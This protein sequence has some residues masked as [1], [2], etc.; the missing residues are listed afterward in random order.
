MTIIIQSE[1]EPA[2]ASS[3]S[4]RSRNVT[5]RCG[6]VPFLFESNEVVLQYKVSTLRTA[7]LKNPTS[8][9]TTWT[10][11]AFIRPFYEMYDGGGSRSRPACNRDG[12]ITR[13]IDRLTLNIGREWYQMGDFG[14]NQMWLICWAKVFWWSPAGGMSRWREYIS[15]NYSGLDY[16]IYLLDAAKEHKDRRLC[17]GLSIVNANWT[18]L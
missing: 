17:N 18:I 5:Q 2:S 11:A 1:T 9:K 13:H 14:T 4:T 3:T 7:W 12:Q 10:T 8:K 16:H 6:V 15:P